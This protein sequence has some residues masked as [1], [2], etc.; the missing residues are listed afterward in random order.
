LKESISRFFRRAF[1]EVADS[2]GL[3]F[4][5]VTGSFFW[6]IVVCGTFSMYI[7]IMLY[8]AYLLHTSALVTIITSLVPMALGWYYVARK[9][10]RNYFAF[11]LAPQKIYD[12]EKT[13]RE[14]LELLE[15]QKHKRIKR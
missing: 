3:T 9:R 11:L 12:T 13:I 1:L 2:L 15:N 10:E 5:F 14:Y 6:L 8:V 7:W 4:E